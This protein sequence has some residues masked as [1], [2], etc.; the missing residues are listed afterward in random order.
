MRFGGKKKRLDFWEWAGELWMDKGNCMTLKEPEIF[1]IETPTG[2]MRTHV[3]RPSGEGKYPG[4]LMYSEIFQVT[5]PIRRMASW[6]AGQGF[7]VAVP[8]VYH[9]FEEA[10]TVLAYDG[11]GAARGNA[12]K[13]MKSVEA[14]DGDARAAV[15]FLKGHPGSTGRIGAM[16]ICLGGHLAWRA[17]MNREVLATGCFYATD[18][19]EGT[20]GLGMKDDSLARVGEI[21]GELLMVWGRQD[22]H[23]PLAGRL[24]IHAALEASGRY[25]QWHEVNG[26]HAFMRDEGLRYN[27]VLAEQGYGLAVEMF[28]RC[29]G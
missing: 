6:F 20:L 28:R 19:D 27:P 29:L 11:E 7:V 16:G 18:L 9:E 12:L 22:P 17:A 4:L 10:G 14:F 15:E 1:E 25:F 23:V 26:A 21:E 5:G 3:F 8:E 2:A 13:V 24:K